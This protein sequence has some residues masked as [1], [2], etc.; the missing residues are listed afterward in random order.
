MNSCIG[1]TKLLVNI[2]IIFFYKFN[3]CFYVTPSYCCTK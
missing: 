1:A 2:N 3:N